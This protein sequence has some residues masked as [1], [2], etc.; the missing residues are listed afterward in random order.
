MLSAEGVVKL[1]DYLTWD[2]AAT[3]PCAAVTAWHALTSGG[4][5]AEEWVL[6]QGSGGVSVFALQ[7]ARLRG[8]RVFTISGKADKLARLREMGAESGVN[9]REVP[10]WDKAAREA[11]GGRGVDHVVEVGGSGTLPLSIKAARVGGK[12]HMIGAL[13]GR[14][15]IAFVPV[16]MRNLWVHG[17][18]VGSR[19]MFEDMLKAMEGA[20]LR[21]VIDRRF[22]F[23][24]L[25]DAMRYMEQGQHFGKVVVTC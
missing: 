1:P 7:F 12:V 3:L 9:Y 22:R 21:P 25:P 16:F 2:E 19:Q 10:E 8:A 24:E 23:D 14:D 18:Y 5:R 15:E 17:I 13:A 4:V 20:Q 11:T 6:T